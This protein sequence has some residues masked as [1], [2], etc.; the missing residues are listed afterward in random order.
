MHKIREFFKGFTEGLKEF[1]ESINKVVNLILLVPAYFIGVGS[2]SI[3]T[4][5]VGKHFLDIKL[6]KSKTYWS[7]LNLKKKP[8][9]K[10][11]RQF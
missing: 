11:Y 8:I 10:Y 6:S 7:N 3:F 9:E 5:L 2:T 1:S 4:K